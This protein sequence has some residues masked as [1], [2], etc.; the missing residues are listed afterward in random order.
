[1]GIFYPLFYFLKTGVPMTKKTI[2]TCFCKRSLMHSGY[3]ALTVLALVAI[4]FSISMS[5]GIFSIETNAQSVQIIAANPGDSITLSG[6][7][8]PNINVRLSVSGSI[9]LAVSNSRY[10]QT[11][12]GVYI[13]GG[14]SSF[15]LRVSPV[16]TLSVSG[17]L[18]GTPITIVKDGTISGDT[19]SLSISGIPEGTY[20]IT[21]LGKTS[22]SSVSATVTASQTVTSNS[23]GD[24]SISENT[25]GLPPTVYSVT[26]NGQHIADVYLGVPPPPT[27]TPT[28]TITATPTVTVTATAT[29][30]ATV[31]ASPTV[32]VSPSPN[33][34]TTP[35]PTSSP[36]ATVSPEPSVSPSPTI[37]PSPTVSPSV[38][39][40]PTTSHGGVS[41]IIG[42]I[43]NFLT[44]PTGAPTATPTP[45]PNPS[46]TPT[47]AGSIV[48]SVTPHEQTTPTPTLPTMTILYV[49]AII[50][51]VIVAG[52]AIYL[53]LRK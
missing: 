18:R 35:T 47:D 11:L 51:I 25:N 43:V 37:S 13:P 2:W 17:T 32:T 41:G 4:V 1:M 53:R 9:T 30:T 23:N 16:T 24:Y 44:N 34:T 7:T 26:A 28:V 45:T 27:P 15:S 29:A 10:A 31:T 48:V 50:L 19:G 21:I 5:S 52:V 33:S 38:S 12:K 36:N 22:G 40:S 49:V 8:S 14:G 46:G 20:D 3:K 39:P 6:H 42:S